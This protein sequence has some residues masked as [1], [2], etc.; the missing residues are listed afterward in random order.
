MPL[1][2][3]PPSPQS[4]FGTTFRR[5][6]WLRSLTFGNATGAQYWLVALAMHWPFSFR[7]SNTSPCGLD[8]EEEGGGELPESPPPAELAFFSTGLPG[9]QRNSPPWSLHTPCCTVTLAASDGAA[10][11]VF[12]SRA[13]MN[14]RETLVSTTSHW[15]PLCLP[16][17]AT[18]SIT[19]SPP[20]VV[21]F[22]FAGTS[23]S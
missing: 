4:A 1:F 11:F 13:M 23:C 16:A 10:P 6:Q 17:Q 22:F 2:F 7:I 19:L 12:P 8:S 14:A 5:P 9:R 20:S 21:A 3:S 15:S 18:I